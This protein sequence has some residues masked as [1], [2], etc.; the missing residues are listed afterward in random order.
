MVT[1]QHSAD[2]G[3][4]PLPDASAPHCVDTATH[5]KTITPPHD[6]CFFSPLLNI[7]ATQLLL[8]QHKVSDTYAF[9]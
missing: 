1:S 8:R 6:A 3:S 2:L 5:I 9:C 4:L 7:S